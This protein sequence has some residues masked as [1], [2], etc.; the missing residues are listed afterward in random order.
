MS[1]KVVGAADIVVCA[2]GVYMPEDPE[3]KN[4]LGFAFV[5]YS[6]PQ[7]STHN[8]NCMQL[9]VL[10]WH[11]KVTLTSASNE[12]GNIHKAFAISFSCH[13]WK[14]DALAAD[15]RYAARNSEETT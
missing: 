9:E 10:S 11:S 13:L 14:G 1:E 5:E 4:T 12:T 8:L 3:T 15:Q 7:V 6:T 2:G